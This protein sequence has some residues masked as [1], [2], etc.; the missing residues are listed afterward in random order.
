MMANKTANQGLGWLP[1]YHDMGLIGHVLHPLY[2][3]MTSRLMSQLDFV[4]KPVRWLR[5]I[6]KFGA[7]ISGG[8]SFAYQA[9]LERIHDEGLTLWPRRRS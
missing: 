1:L 6:S 7:T 3:G 2:V 4:Q 9:C 5:A 8:P